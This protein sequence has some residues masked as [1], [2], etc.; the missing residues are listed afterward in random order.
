MK[1]NVYAVVEQQLFK[2]K[3]YR[4]LTGKAPQVL[5][6]FLCRRQ[7]VKY[8]KKGHERWVCTNAKELIF[9]YTE[10][11]DKWE[12][13]NRQFTPA[14]DQLIKYGFID[15]VTPGGELF[16]SAT[17]YGL[18]ERWRKYNLPEFTIK[19]RAKRPLG[20]GYCKKK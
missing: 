4:S 14:I 7:M 20:Y 8:G 17:V 15:I 6:L 1:K 13:T 9:T 10:A 12:I 16:K 5:A 3:A 11:N 2:S 18:S 19:T